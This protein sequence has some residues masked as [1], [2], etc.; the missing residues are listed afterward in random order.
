MS[1]EVKFTPLAEGFIKAKSSLE[2]AEGIARHEM[3][4]LM[5]NGLEKPSKL[6]FHCFEVGD[7]ELICHGKD[8]GIL[9]DTCS[10]DEMDEAVKVGPLAGKKLM[11]PR[12][13]SEA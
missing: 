3:A 6:Y 4:D 5:E 10:Y 8:Y 11:M 2:T 7:L 1:Y 13:D 12:G 9:I